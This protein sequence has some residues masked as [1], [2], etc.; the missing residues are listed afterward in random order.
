MA[1][2]GYENGT[3]TLPGKNRRGASPFE[4]RRLDI[5]GALNARRDGTASPSVLAWRLARARA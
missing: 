1:A 4:L 3:T 5:D 2:A